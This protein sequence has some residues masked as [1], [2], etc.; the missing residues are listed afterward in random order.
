MRHDVAC[1]IE[2]LQV[3]YSP[4]LRDPVA[5]AGSLVR[6]HCVPVPG[7]R[8]CPTRDSTTRGTSGLS[9]RRPADP[10]PH[11]ALGDPAL[12]APVDE[13]HAGCHLQRPGDDPVVEEED[14]MVTR[15]GG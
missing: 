14:G 10:V 15:P 2:R 4:R 9:V 8:A 5:R 11:W 3:D 13:V 6:R 1:V 7:G 12:Y